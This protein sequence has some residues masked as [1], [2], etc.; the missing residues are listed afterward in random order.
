MNKGRHN[1]IYMLAGTQGDKL[2]DVIGTMSGLLKNLPQYEGKF[3]SS[4]V[5]VLKKLATDR[6]TGLDLI[7]FEKKMKRIGTTHDWRQK[8]FE[9]IQKMTLPELAAFFNGNLAPLKYNILVVGK[10]SAADRRK[11]AGYGE[12]VDLNLQEIF[13]Y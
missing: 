12:I 7:N 13:G 9:T 8:E 1:V 10:I 2:F 11:L 3:T 5:S 6:V 4:K